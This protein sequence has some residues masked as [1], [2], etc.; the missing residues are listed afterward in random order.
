[1]NKLDN[2]RVVTGVAKTST[3]DNK[4]VVK[5]CFKHKVTG[6]LYFFSYEELKKMKETTE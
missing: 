3:I 1:M 2:F 5:Q 6:D 4:R